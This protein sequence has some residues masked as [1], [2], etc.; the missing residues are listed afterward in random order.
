ME[1]QVSI[2]IPVYNAFEDLRKCVESIE[3]H[4]NLS[5]VNLIF[6]NDNSS[7][8]RIAPYLNGIKCENIT[9]M[10]NC[11]NFGFSHNVNIGIKCSRDRDVIL[12][13][14]DTIVTHGWVEKLS[15]CAYSASDIG[16]VTPFSNNAT[17]CSLPE[18]C[19]DNC[20][21][22]EMTID[23]FAAMV[24][25]CSLHRYPDIPV[26]VGFCMYIKRE[27]IN[28]IG[29]FDEATFQR[30]YGEENDF[31]NR[32]QLFGYRH[33]L[34]DDTF[35]YHSGTM[36]FLAEEKKKLCK[37][38]ERILN[39]R[40]P[41]LESEKNAFVQSN[42][43]W[44]FQEMIQLCSLLNPS[45]K[46][47]LYIVHRDFRAD[48][49]DSVGGTQFHV[50]DL[51]NGLVD[52]YNILV[53]ARSYSKLNLTLYGSNA[54]RLIQFNVG[55]AHAVQHFYDN[56]I[57]KICIAIIDL[58]KVNI[59]HV[60]HVIDLSLD[61]FYIAAERNIPIYFTVHDFY[62]ICPRIVLLDYQDKYCGNRID[63]E[64]CKKCLSSQTWFANQVPFEIDF[65]G[66]W[67][68]RFLNA[69]QKCTMIFFPSNSARQIFEMVYP[70]L[71][72]KG[73][74]IPHASVLPESIEKPRKID[75]CESNFEEVNVT[76]E[77][78]YAKG[79]C[80]WSKHKTSDFYVN[81]KITLEDGNNFIYPCTKSKCWDPT[82]EEGR[83]KFGMCSFEAI[84]PSYSMQG[85]YEMCIVMED[86]EFSAYGKTFSFQNNKES[87][88]ADEFR[89]AFVG[90]LCPSKGS[91]LI[92]SLVQ[93]KANG[94][95][96]ILF[97][98]IA[99]QQLIKLENNS[100]T[101]YGKYHRREI[102]QALRCTQVDLVCI[103]AIWPETFCY[104]LSEVVQA[105][106]PVLCTDI[107]A[108]GER[109]R[110]GNLGWLLPPISD[111]DTF[112]EKIESIRTDKLTY[113]KIKEKVKLHHENTLQDMAHA[114]S[115]CYEN[116]TSEN[117]IYSKPDLTLFN[118]AFENQKLSRDY[119][120]LLDQLVETKSI[121]EKLQLE[122]NAIHQSKAY[123]LL[124]KLK[125]LKAL[126]D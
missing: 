57:R 110:E 84:I 1:H 58:F 122:L 72:D 118:A 76:H 90:G 123:K 30:G 46:T 85:K 36:S 29:Y 42:P 39:S 50:E 40:Y 73:V 112:L 79:W 20:I 16:T 22:G 95:T 74:V 106:I 100:L 25:Q 97:G 37:L 116:V 45:K 71:A 15:Q 61:I 33:V 17:I 21:P 93:K 49:Q 19:K 41:S 103:P 5:S 4:T 35:I 121:Q 8:M 28:A 63:D 52:K 125:R 109:V 43:L 53:L 34:C 26:A 23:D 82:D 119:S 55:P 92:T 98:E 88:K 81:I 31:C 114:Y 6:I 7:D 67:R 38:N 69:M 117:A 60:H 48:A 102:V 44:K 64:R 47:I 14:T 12:L 87:K 62:S 27:L 3:K 32:A 124:G 120:L 51:K 10:H 107:G 59:I 65:I 104:V 68:N 11:G 91:Q 80:K 78:G 66:N 115:A 70:T 89:V 108:L 54:D 77:S 96:W 86:G 2:V 9:V 111:A 56:N 13:N 18:F 75:M 101:K 83:I 24:E 94:I 99:D 126:L 105:G 113:S